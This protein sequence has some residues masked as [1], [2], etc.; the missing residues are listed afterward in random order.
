[1]PVL[2]SSYG[3]LRHRT[4]SVPRSARIF[5]ADS[6]LDAVMLV[7]GSGAFALFLAYVTLC[8]NL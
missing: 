1:M 3:F 4:G 8:A 6:M 2:Q 5:G 7:L